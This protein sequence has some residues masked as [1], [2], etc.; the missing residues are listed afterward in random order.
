MATGGFHDT[1]P[2]YWNMNL[3]KQTIKTVAEIPSVMPNIKIHFKPHPRFDC[4]KYIKYVCDKHSDLGCSYIEPNSPLSKHLPQADIV[5]VLDTGTSAAIEAVLY[6]KPII[7][8]L[9]ARSPYC[10]EEIPIVK[11]EG[12]HCVYS[13]GEIISSIKKIIHNS[14]FRKDLIKKEQSFIHL[15]AYKLDGHATDRIVDGIEQI[16]KHENANS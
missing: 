5:L 3:H 8:A 9:T 13:D 12:A 11:W 16:A 7:L 14:D 10:M 4:A 15:Y 1:I 2:A 6:G